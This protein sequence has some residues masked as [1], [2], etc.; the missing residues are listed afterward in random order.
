VPIA[1]TIAKVGDFEGDG[2]AD[3]LWRETTSG[4]VA[5]WFMNGGPLPAPAGL[6]R[7]PTAWTAQ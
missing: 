7:I 3:L 5:L 2:E 6:G 1:W 4:A